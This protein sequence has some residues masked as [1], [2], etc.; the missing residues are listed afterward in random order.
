ML[1][2]IFKFEDDLLKHHIRT[3]AWL[4]LCKKRLETLRKIGNPRKPRKL[5]YF[6]FCA[7]GAIDVLMLDVA[8]V[9]RPSK[10]RG[11][12]SVFFFDETP[13]HV[14]ET[15]K[16]IPG[17]VGFPGDFIKI[18]LMEDPEEDTVVDSDNIL[19]ASSDEL[20][21]YQTRKHQL[22]LAQRRK[23]I[24]AFP[25]D[26]INLDLEEFLFKPND[27]L[28]GRMINAFRKVFGWQRRSLSTS[29]IN[30]LGLDGF[31]LMFTTQIGPPNFS[32][33]YLAMLQRRLDTNLATFSTLKPL[34]NLKTGFDNVSA[35]R[36]EKFDDFFKLAM[37][38]RIDC[39]IRSTIVKKVRNS[40]FFQIALDRAE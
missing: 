16:R 24:N 21:T 9:I 32:S 18:V 40:E 3:E 8:K 2:G 29:P 36:D 19:Q 30:N 27:P 20:D 17:A 28:P 39:A 1:E 25:F 34:M 13:Q 31:S 7:V 38:K 33:D 22:K 11:F 6:T 14:V 5:R 4:P 12:D 15:R 10:D 35:L 26:V 23:F 37:P